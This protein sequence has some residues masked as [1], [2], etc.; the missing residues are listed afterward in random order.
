MQSSTSR[1]LPGKPVR[2]SWM[3]NKSFSVDSTM[4]LQERTLRVM[5]RLLSLIIVLY[6]RTHTSGAP[7]EE[8]VGDG[9]LRPG[10]EYSTR[11]GEYTRR[12]TDDYREEIVGTTQIICLRLQ[13]ACSPTCTA[14]TT[15]TLTISDG[16][17]TT[18]WRALALMAEVYPLIHFDWTAPP[19]R[20]I[21]P[22]FIDHVPSLRMGPRTCEHQ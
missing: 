21:R 7:V 8:W 10:T 12:P 11:R 14:G 19:W 22:S 9:D 6:L 17:A 1:V 3:N 18:L 5:F 2:Y 4:I 20:N 13:S 15:S 16:D